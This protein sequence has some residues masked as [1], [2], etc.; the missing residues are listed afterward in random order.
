M[1]SILLKLEIKIAGNKGTLD[2]FMKSLDLREGN[3][4]ITKGVIHAEAYVASEDE[5]NSVYT[6]HNRTLLNWVR[7][8]RPE[9]V[10]A[11]AK[12]LNKDVSNLSKVLRSLAKFSLV[13]L[14]EGESARRTLSAFVDWDQLEVKFPIPSD[15]GKR[16]SGF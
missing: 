1:A 5:F 3:P 16:A 10:Y 2:S 11:M 15:H 8:N 14:E 6:A 9:S 4:K 12:A 13:R 7:E